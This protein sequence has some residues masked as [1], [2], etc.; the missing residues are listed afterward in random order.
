MS[1]SRSRSRRGRGARLLAPL[2]LAALAGCSLAPREPVRLTVLAT[3]DFHGAL[4]SSHQEPESGRL[5]GGAPELAATIA[6]ER[7]RNA[8][9]TVLVDAGDILHGTALSNL[10]EGR[11][12]I[13]FYNLLTPDASVAGNH[14][15]D[16]GVEALRRRM[17]EASFPILLAN[18]Q[19]RATGEAPDWARSHRIVE[20]RGV[21]IA[22]V[23]VTTESLPEETL[24]QHVAD[25][26]FTDPIAAA[27]AVIDELVPSRADLAVV[28][29]HC[30]L[31]D[32]DIFGTEIKE[33]AAALPQAAAIVAGHTHERHALRISGVP[34]IQP[35]A[36]GRYLG[37][38]DLLVDRRS[39]RVTSAE[40]EIVP[41]YADAV[42][43]DPEAVRR[44]AGYRAEVESILAEE[45]G[46]AAV[47]LD[48]DPDEECRL[49]NLLTDT[50]RERFGVD[51]AF[52][53][54]LGVRAPIAAGTV[55][56]SDVYRALPFDNTVV[57]MEL[58]GAQIERMLSEADAASRTLYAS[59]LR[60]AL[61]PSRPPGERVRVV[62]ELQNDRT[63]RVAVNN[64]MAQ[65]GENLS[66]LEAVEG[67]DTGVLL[68]DVLADHI[69]N[70]AR[71]GEAVS[72]EIDGRIAV[73]S[74]E[75]GE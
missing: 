28:V 16:W 61:D 37:R 30:G 50:I 9:G 22:L 32:G 21:R 47:T 55:R 10:T 15:F 51:M 56:F 25:Y 3:A 70:R 67:T 27:R 34:V 44:L 7:A 13:D 53:N 49:G 69:R 8:E 45:I 29:C 35:G 23:G 40:A 26:R 73:R 31:S 12:S 71:S 33:L 43:P 66:S 74:R 75:I 41:V 54:A 68:R 59:G 17:E 18:V 57:L 2:L 5:L 38:V 72:A 63:Y 46:T 6:R 52:Q 36:A 62:T 24:A 19:E 58:S 65:G 1:V 64:Y 20:R 4:E 14:E 60:Y 39:K 42:E 11:T 48:Q